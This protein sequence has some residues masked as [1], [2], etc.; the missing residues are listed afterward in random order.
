MACQKVD[1]VDEPAR[2]RCEQSQ[3][4]GRIAR[5]GKWRGRLV[6]VYAWC[7]GCPEQLM[8]AIAGQVE[9]VRSTR[10]PLEFSRQELRCLLAV[11]PAA[12]FSS[13]SRMGI[14]CR[15]VTF[16]GCIFLDS[17]FSEDIF[18]LNHCAIRWTRQRG[19]NTTGRQP[20]P[21]GSTSA[22]QLQYNISWCVRLLLQQITTHVSIIPISF[23]RFFEIDRH[24]GDAT[25]GRTATESHRRCTS[26]QYLA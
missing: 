22:S 26:L 17:F 10:L 23:P 7:S 1:E 8:V 25:P 20:A 24:E 14:T 4:L 11:C 15:D 9:Y 3:R 16:D 18:E 6:L 13:T 2:G 21:A 12:F 5:R 19:A